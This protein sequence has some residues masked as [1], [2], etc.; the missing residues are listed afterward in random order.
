[1][2][3]SVRL[4]VPS[5]HTLPSP[6]STPEAHAAAIVRHTRP[7]HG[8]QSRA[9]SQPGSSPGLFFHTTDAIG[10]K[11]QPRYHEHSVV[12][13]YDNHRPHTTLNVATPNEVYH[14]LLPACEQPRFEPRPRWPS[15]STCA[16]PRA[17]KRSAI[18]MHVHIGFLHGRKHLPVIT[19]KHAA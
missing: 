3:R 11:R 19:L 15:T 16:S 5:T 7:S 18:H 4:Q 17:P 10:I 6:S 9:V 12:W 8:E 13:L 2:R 1:M 14:D